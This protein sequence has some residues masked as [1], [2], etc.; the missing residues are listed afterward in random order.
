[1]NT[2]RLRIKDFIAPGDASHVGRTVFLDGRG[3]AYH[4][5]DF[6]EVFW[7]EKGKGLHRRNGMREELKP[8]VVCFIR[9][10]DRHG[11]DARANDG[12]SIMNVAF[13]RGVVADLASRYAKEFHPWP[14]A[15][16][17]GARVVVD[18]QMAQRLSHAA[19]DLSQHPGS[20]L[21]LDRFLMDVLMLTRP[22]IPAASKAAG[23]SWLQ[24]ASQAFNSPA[25]FAGGVETFSILTGRSPEHVNRT[26]RSLLGVT[27]TQYINTLRL[28]WA[29]R[30]L[31]MT[32]SNI[33]TIAM[34]AG[35]EN[36]SYF[37]RLFK[38]RHAIT[39][40][41]YR[42]KNRGPLPME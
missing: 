20:R 34:D 33:T 37:I 1:M 36:V 18:A 8:G 14:W 19:Q 22:S 29:Q 30:Q 21:R 12:L 31:R 10:Q 17:A 3:V 9:P 28:D 13:A 15:R 26:L 27:T 38:T 11:F 5:H 35:F 25:Q 6:A 2:P 32:E 39:P 40:A 24:E 23:P 7:V 41:A 42:E 4:G 16:P